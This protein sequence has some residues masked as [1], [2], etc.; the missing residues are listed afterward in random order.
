MENAL[1]VTLFLC[2][3][4]LI[5]NNLLFTLIKGYQCKGLKT[6]YYCSSFFIP[7]LSLL[8]LYRIL[9]VFMPHNFEPCLVVIYAVL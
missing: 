4:T 5:W 8:F 1:Q 9:M 2:V 3:K 7:L 6:T